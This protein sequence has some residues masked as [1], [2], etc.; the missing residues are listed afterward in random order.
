VVARA[1]VVETAAVGGPAGQ[2]AYLNGAWLVAS[3]LGPHQLLHLLQA[4]ETAL[5]RARAVRWG[6]RSIDLDLLLRSDGAVVASPVLTLPHP[7][8]HERPFVLGPLAEIAGEWRH[9]LLGVSIA[10]LWVRSA[11]CGVR[12]ATNP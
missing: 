10:D 4:I 12:S 5:G 2:G 3:A 6:A 1:A 8:L 11:E 9:P 7:R